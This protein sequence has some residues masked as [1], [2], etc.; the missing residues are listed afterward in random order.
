MS[1]AKPT[2]AFSDST[3]QFLSVS[4]ALGGLDSI[5]ASRGSISPLITTPIE[6][7]FMLFTTLSTFVFGARRP[8]HAICFYPTPLTQHCVFKKMPSHKVNFFLNIPILNNLNR[9]K[10]IKGLIFDWVRIAGSRSGQLS[11]SSFSGTKTWASNF[12]KGTV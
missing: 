5:L 9:K 4:A 12:S 3:F 2:K 6:A 10:H 1:L 8:S 7:F 11:G